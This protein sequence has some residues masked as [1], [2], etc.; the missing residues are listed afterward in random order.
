MVDNEKSGQSGPSSAPFQSYTGIK[1]LRKLHNY[2]KH[3]KSPIHTFVHS[4]H[5]ALQLRHST[6]TPVN[7]ERNDY[8]QPMY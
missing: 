3:D 7:D 4:L 2:F 6:S 5:K 1:L 8:A